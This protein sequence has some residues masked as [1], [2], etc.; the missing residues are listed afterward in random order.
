MNAN[1]TALCTRCRALI[2]P[3]PGPPWCHVCYGAIAIVGSAMAEKRL[4]AG[5]WPLAPTAHE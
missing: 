2:A 5:E 3:Q 1:A 4:L